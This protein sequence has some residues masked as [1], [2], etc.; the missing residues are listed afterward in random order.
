MRILLV[1]NE[2]DGT[3]SE[4]IALLKD[5][6]A[7]CAQADVELLRH[8]DIPA[9]GVLKGEYDCI[10]LSGREITWK[11]EE[12]PDE[13]RSELDLIRSTALPVLG[14]C[15]GHELIGMALGAQFGS[16]PGGQGEV[17]EEGFVELEITIDPI[18]EGISSPCVCFSYHGDELKSMPDSC[19][20]LA[21]SAM[22]GIHA[23]RHRERPIYGLQFHPEKY[24]EDHPHGRTILENFFRIAVS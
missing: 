21:K 20:L 5:R 14:I 24:D 9:S 12:L 15:A 22:C 3:V 16:M 19:L 18:F 8:V 13:Y 23:I 17:Q 6:V 4:W 2:K 11:I 1:N 7:V 10:V